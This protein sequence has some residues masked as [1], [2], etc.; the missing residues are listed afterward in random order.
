LEREQRSLGEVKYDAGQLG[1]VIA[2]LYSSYDLGWFGVKFYPTKTKPKYDDA[3]F[4]R[5]ELSRAVYRI[6]STVG[7]KSSN[8]GSIRIDYT[9]FRCRQKDNAL[10]CVTLLLPVKVDEVLS[11]REK[12]AAGLEQHKKLE[13][14]KELKRKQ[15]KQVSLPAKHS[16]GK[17]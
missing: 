12:K 4:W 8:R 3:L 9:P 1:S 17:K 6:Q 7:S 16:Q 2:S 10:E 14:E 5:N 13:R 15:K 11:R